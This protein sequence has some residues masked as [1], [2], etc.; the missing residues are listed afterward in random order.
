[1]ALESSLKFAIGEARKA[2]KAGQKRM[3]TNIQ[4]ERQPAEKRPPARAPESSIGSLAM[5]IEPPTTPARPRSASPPPPAPPDAPPARPSPIAQDRDFGPP[6]FETL[7]GA[8]IPPPQAPVKPNPTLP[9]LEE[10]QTILVIDD[11]QVALKLIEGVLTKRRYRVITALHGREGL[12]RMK[13][14]APDL[15]ICDGMLPEVHGFEICK[16][17]KT[18]DRFKHIPVMLLSA[19]HTGW[20]FAEDV[21]EKYGA[22]DYV[23]KPFEAA[24]LIRRVE[25]LLN[26]S[27]PV[28][29]E[30]EAAVRQHL[31]EG[32]V[33]LKNSRLDEAIA[34]FE[35]GLK[36]DQFNDM[37]HYYLAMTLEKN[38]RIFD[39]CD[40]YEKA[41]QINPQFF[42]AITSLANLY[43]R[44]E[45][46]RKAREMWELALGATKDEGVR[47]RIKEHILSLL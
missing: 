44:Q 37:L 13:E 47:A 30:S 41:V 12:A 15:V 8:T 34:S 21:K 19:V 24:D 36:V 20:R 17:I 43:Q 3:T 5:S 4:H 46:L 33:A 18:S 23:T 1:V 11:S 26:R 27:S 10:M 40:H 25:T 2:V 6:I 14:S 31:K 29:P 16:Q 7:A 38:E 35:R 45:F 42:D 39:A 28:P 9:A 32:V 22:D